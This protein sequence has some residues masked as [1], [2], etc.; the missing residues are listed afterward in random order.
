MNSRAEDSRSVDAFTG[1][2]CWNRKRSTK[3]DAR[4]YLQLICQGKYASQPVDRQFS[5]SPQGVQVRFRGKEE[6]VDQ[7]AETRIFLAE[8]KYYASS[9]VEPFRFSK[10]S[11]S[12]RIRQSGVF[13]S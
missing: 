2:P 3:D 8:L 9:F 6:I 7:R 10:V 5:P 1:E 11:T 4:E 13:R 12:K